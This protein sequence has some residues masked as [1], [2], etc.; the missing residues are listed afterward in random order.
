MDINM[1]EIRKHCPHE[2]ITEASIDAI[3]AR[4]KAKK[5]E[6]ALAQVASGHRKPFKPETKLEYYQRTRPGWI[7]YYEP[8]I[9][10]LLTLQGY[11]IPLLARKLLTCVPLVTAL[12]WD[13]VDRG[14][15]AHCGFTRTG[16]RGVVPRRFTYIW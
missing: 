5:K 9:V 4:R 16:K 3:Y 7:T 1:D 6:V 12:V 14:E 13:L 8:Q 15:V 11:T 2:P 10:R